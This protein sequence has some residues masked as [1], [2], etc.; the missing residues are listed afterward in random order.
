LECRKR[1]G[2]CRIATW[3]KNACGALAVGEDNFYGGAWGASR[4]EAESKALTHC[5][6]EAQNC[7]IRRWVC[8]GR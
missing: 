2:G 7:N 5:R 1:G 8:T 4:L 3:F 6:K